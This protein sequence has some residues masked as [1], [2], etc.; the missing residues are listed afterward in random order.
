VDGN[1]A[2]WR[3]LKEAIWHSVSHTLSI[4]VFRVNTG[5]A[6]IITVAYCFMVCWFLCSVSF[7]DTCHCCGSTRY[8]FNRMLLV[9]CK[10]SLV[11]ILASKNCCILIDLLLQMLLLSGPNA[12]LERAKNDGMK[13]CQV[14]TKVQVLCHPCHCLRCMLATMLVL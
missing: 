8:C 10:G 7:V 6:R 13:A 9:I 14:S 11:L 4:D 5:P 1:I 3:N 12:I 2:V